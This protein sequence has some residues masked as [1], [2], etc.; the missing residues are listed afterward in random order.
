MKMRHIFLLI[1][2][3][4]IHYIS[5]AAVEDGNEISIITPQYSE[6]VYYVNGSCGND[7]WRGISPSC[8]S[9]DGPKKTIQAAIN[10][11]AQE[12]LIVIYPGTYYEN[13]LLNSKNLAITST[14]AYDSNIV[15]TT[16]IDGAYNESVIRAINSDCLLKGLSIKHG[17]GYKGGGI[18][19]TGNLTL[20]KCLISNNTTVNGLGDPPIPPGPEF[21]ENLVFHSS[22]I[23]NDP[24][25]GPG[26]GI[27]C[28]NALIEDCNISNNTTGKGSGDYFNPILGNGGNGAGIYCTG[29]VNIVN[30]IIANNNCGQSGGVHQG[31]SRIGGNG[32]GIYASSSSLIVIM[33]SNISNNKAGDE[34]KYGGNGG[35]GGGIYCEGQAEIIVSRITSNSTGH[36]LV[37]GSGGGI[38]FTS[39]S[40]VNMIDCN[41]SDNKAANGH[42]HQAYGGGRGGSGGGIYCASQTANFENCNFID[43]VCGNGACAE[44]SGYNNGGSGGGIIIASQTNIIMNQCIFIGNRTGDGGCGGRTSG[45]SGADG[46]AIC[47]F[48]NSATFLNCIINNNS[49]GNGGDSWTDNMYS[50]SG[51]YG[52]N[53]GRGAGI[54]SEGGHIANCIIANNITGNGGNGINFG[55]NKLLNGGNGGNGGGIYSPSSSVINCIITSNLTGQGGSGISG[56]ADGIDGRGA[57]YCDANSLIANSILWNEEIEQFAGQDSNN[58]KYCDIIDSNY[59]GVNGN[60]CADPLFVN[61]DANDFHLAINSPCIDAGDN[62]FVPSEV[63]TDFDGYLRFYDA[64]L[65]PDTGNGTAPIVDIGPYEYVLKIFNESR[66]TYHSSIQEAIDSAEAG[67]KI[68]VDDGIYTGAGN[69]DI[70]FGGKDLTLYSKE[71]AVI[72]CM[73]TPAEP[74]RAFKFVSGETNNSVIDGFTIINGFAPEEIWEDIYS[75]GGAIYCEDAS[76]AIKNCKFINNN[77]HDKGGAICCYNSTSNISNCTFEYSNSVNGGAIYNHI[78]NI[79]VRN[80]LFNQNFAAERGGAMFNSF[81]IPAAIN[82]TFYNNQALVA[83]GAIRNNYSNSQITNSILWNNS[84]LEDLQISNHVSYPV[85]SYCDISGGYSGTGNF[86]AD[87]YFADAE[88]GDFHLQSQYGRWDK[89]LEQWVYDNH[90]SPCIDSGNPASDW[91]GELWP[92]GKRINMGFYGGTSQAS[93]SASTEGNIADLNNNESVNNYDLM[94]IAESWLTEENLLKED[95]NRDGSVDFRDYVIFADN[96]RWYGI[97]QE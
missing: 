26:G 79:I 75:S 71:C 69:R 24:N 8:S 96:W 19:S 9:P 13:L 95:L 80:C 51:Y 35:N 25:G 29:E 15:E 27:Y 70:D 7:S 56:G 32:G 72:D 6:T 66:S 20:K 86:E 5:N 60:I 45:S 11:A 62:N 34:D 33:H 73:G 58:V 12:D 42:Y 22:G 61:A 65:T 46:G 43:N 68:R 36:G 50:G 64:P 31:C 59:A 76:P 63:T 82:C 87:P 4:Q 38:L 78:S 41:I 83:G 97:P 49:T 23:N 48:S 16:I 88:N 67:N 93:M 17:Y 40:N 47:C 21:V 3:C 28:D 77:S 89:N 91:Q 92:H 39:T 1:L 54:Y 74:H 55:G 18:Y 30:C 37:S 81:G 10:T 53:G 94:M 85:I 52:G 84:S 2:F 90:T 14:D 44:Y 57:I